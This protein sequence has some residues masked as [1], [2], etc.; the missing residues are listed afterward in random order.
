MENSL[1]SV[2]SLAG[3]DQFVDTQSAQVAI[4][5][6]ILLHLVRSKSITGSYANET[7]FKAKP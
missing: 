4:F 6:L 3:A 5:R 1:N 7:S 2:S